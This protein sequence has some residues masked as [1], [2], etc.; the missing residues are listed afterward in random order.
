M[1]WLC[2]LGLSV[3]VNLS[4]LEVDAA[5]I[6]VDIAQE[7]H[8]DQRADLAIDCA[9][10]RY[11][12]NELPWQLYADSSIPDRLCRTFSERKGVHEAHFIRLLRRRSMRRGA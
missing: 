5:S 8:L 1:E 6:H 3:C 7:G 2:A 11:H 12:V 10:K 9:Q 4:T